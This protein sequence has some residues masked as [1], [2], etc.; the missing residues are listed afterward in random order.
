MHR[1]H[2]PSSSTTRGPVVIEL[3]WLSERFRHYNEVRTPHYIIY[4]FCGSQ[5]EFPAIS[6]RA[7]FRRFSGKYQN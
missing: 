4:G 6:T 2:E 5:S 7:L 1:W 3:E